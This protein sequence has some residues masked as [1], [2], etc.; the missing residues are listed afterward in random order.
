MSEPTAVIA[1]LIPVTERVA[2]IE[3]PPFTLAH[4]LALEAINHPLTKGEVPEKFV[5]IVRAVALCSI[6]GKDARRLAADPR[7]LESAVDEL[8]ERI[9]PHAV[10]DL[11]E[12]M[13]RQVARAFDSAIRTKAPE[14]ESP[15]A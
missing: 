12:A 1:A 6:P 8:A 7:A 14:G 10:R 5:D 3:L 9:P 11:A 13:A 2:G 15:S 4:W